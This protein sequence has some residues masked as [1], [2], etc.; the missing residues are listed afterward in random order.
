MN[1]AVM[2]A[3][4]GAMVLGGLICGTAVA[5][6]GPGYTLLGAAALFLINLLFG[7]SLSINPSTRFEER[8]SVA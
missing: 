4:Q 5:M 7:A 1:A 3:S 2:T 6:V 8:V